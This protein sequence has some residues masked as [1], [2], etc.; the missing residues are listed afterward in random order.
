MTYTEMY[1]IT[2]IK[3][4]TKFSPKGNEKEGATKSEA[5]TLWNQKELSQI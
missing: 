1:A 3:T 5:V 2:K 4:T